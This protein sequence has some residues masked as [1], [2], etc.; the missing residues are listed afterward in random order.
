MSDPKIPVP[1]ADSHFAIIELKKTG[2]ISV[3]GNVR[4]LHLVGLIRLG[5]ASLLKEMINPIQQPDPLAKKVE[6][7]NTGL[8]GEDRAQK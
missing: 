1:P 3:K 6:E 5:E 4:G 7:T 8:E 2:E